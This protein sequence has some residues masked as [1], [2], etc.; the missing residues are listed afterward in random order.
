MG[1]Y[2][3]VSLGEKGFRKIFEP[4]NVITASKC[5]KIIVTHKLES[6]RWNCYADGELPIA[7]MPLPM[8]PEAA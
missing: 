5:G 6:G 3:E 1:V 2:R 4:A 8:H 7:W